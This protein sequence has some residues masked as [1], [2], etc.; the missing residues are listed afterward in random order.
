MG[1]SLPGTKRLLGAYLPLPKGRTPTVEQ[2]CILLNLS[3][4]QEVHIRQEC[5]HFLRDRQRMQE[6]KHP[7]AP[8]WVKGSVV[9]TDSLHGT[10]VPHTQLDPYFLQL[11]HQHRDIMAPL[12]NILQARWDA[13]RNKRPAV[14]CHKVGTW[15]CDSLQLA[16]S[17][18][19]HP[20]SPN[21]R[22]LRR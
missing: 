9:A 18:P 12:A 21:Q 22:K 13:Y 17:K 5:A 10:P 7:R 11:I 3:T 20:A 1:L 8:P 19:A 6:W 16:T 4:L 14:H 2:L 15:N